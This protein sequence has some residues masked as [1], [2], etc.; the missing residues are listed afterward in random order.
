MGVLLVASVVE[1]GCVVEQQQ[2]QLQQRC[3]SLVC[4]GG[5]ECYAWW[6]R[7]PSYDMT[8][9][10]VTVGDT[11]DSM[12][13]WAQYHRTTTEWITLQEE[14]RPSSSTKGHGHH[15]GE[16]QQ[17]QQQPLDPA[18]TG[19]TAPAALDPEPSHQEGG[20]RSTEH[21]KPLGA[22]AGGCGVLVWG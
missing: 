4:C 5:R 21:G 16:E 18:A 10:W 2:Q 20:A 14:Q 1:C 22:A 3:L 12:H 8:H 9:V 13:L 19:V 15:A 17:Q 11:A 7:V 6:C